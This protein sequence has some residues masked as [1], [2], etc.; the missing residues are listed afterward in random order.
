MYNYW[1]NRVFMG[2][3]KKKREAAVILLYLH[4]H[5]AIALAEKHGDILCIR[6]SSVILGIVKHP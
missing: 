4:R 1:R 3:H 5:V 2:R 6:A